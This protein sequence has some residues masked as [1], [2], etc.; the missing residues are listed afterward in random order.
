MSPLEPKVTGLLNE[1][2]VAI[3][4]GDFEEKKGSDQEGAKTYATKMPSPLEKAN[5]NAKVKLSPK[6]LEP[7]TSTS[8]TFRD[9]FLG[10]I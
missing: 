4:D 1:L 7:K 2:I 8:R 10:Q 6:F 3:L 5:S 9:V